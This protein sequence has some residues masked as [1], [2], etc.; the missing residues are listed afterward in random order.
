MNQF[1]PVFF[2]SLYLSFSFEI[3]LFVVIVINK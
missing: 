2:L 3:D 1:P